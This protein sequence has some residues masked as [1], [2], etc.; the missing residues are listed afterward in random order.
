M[1]DI[2]S[3]NLSLGRWLGVPV[4]LHVF[5]LALAVWVIHLGLLSGS[6]WFALGALG[7]LLLCV[8]LHEMGHVFA[9]HRMGAASEPIVLWPLGGLGQP[10]GIFEP[11]QELV[12][13]LAGPLVSFSA[14]ILS[15]PV[16]LL[17]TRGEVLDLLNPLR[18]PFSDNLDAQACLKLWFWMNWILGVVNL[19]P[20]YPLDGARIVRCVLAAALKPR[21]AS[22][23]V[24]RIGMVLAVL[25]VAAGWIGREEFPIAVMPM[26]LLG[27]FVFFSARQEAERI[28]DPDAE[29]T[30]AFELNPPYGG[31]DRSVQTV[32]RRAPGVLRRWIEQRRQQKLRRKRQTELEEERMVD[33]ILAHIR[34]HGMAGLSGHERALLNRVSARYRERLK[35]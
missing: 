9:A 33:Q 27:L 30:Q 32:R 4:R 18:P 5:F 13:T 7:I 28:L 11:Q 35:E 2:Q 15:L 8:L 6:V 17:M 29:D 23:V 25:M 21:I 14:W 10:S 12:V 16:V 31:N 19:F 26:A 22:A 34:V 24:S 1:R 20:A 3:W